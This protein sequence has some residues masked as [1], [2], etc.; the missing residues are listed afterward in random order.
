MQ[1]QTPLLP[2]G[3]GGGYSRRGLKSSSQRPGCTQGSGWMCLHDS[4]A[5][6]V[7]LLP[8][9]LGWGFLLPEGLVP[10]VIQDMDQCPILINHSMA[11]G[12]GHRV[13]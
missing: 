4:A 5:P 2:R 11:S 7:R 9:Q 10:G 12:L 8:G 6:G 13:P 1:D 3:G